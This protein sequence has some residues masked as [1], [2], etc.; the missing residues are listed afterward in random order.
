MWASGDSGLSLF[1]AGAVEG[2]RGT[3]LVTLH[4]RQHGSSAALPMGSNKIT[5]SQ[6]DGLRCG[7]CFNLADAPYVTQDSFLESAAASQ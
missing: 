3:G 2:L 1:A 7:H 6:S 4:V 5:G